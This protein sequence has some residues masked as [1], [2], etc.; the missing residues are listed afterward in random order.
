[1]RFG[2]TQIATPFNH[3]VPPRWR[4]ET[5]PTGRFRGTYPH[6]SHSVTLFHVF[7]SHLLRMPFGFR[8]TA[9]TLPSGVLQMVASGSPW[10]VGI[11]LGRA[12]CKW[13][14]TSPALSVAE[15]VHSSTMAT[16]PE[17]PL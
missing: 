2:V 9:D 15:W 12:S 8:L 4:F 5:S 16:F 7:L 11:E 6:L 14:V 10:L 3:N 1:L 17:A 13:R